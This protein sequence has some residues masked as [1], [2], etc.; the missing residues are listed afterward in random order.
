[1][2]LKVIFDKTVFVNFKIS[3]NFKQKIYETHAK[4]LKTPKKIH[5]TLWILNM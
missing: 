5:P 4:Q 2:L 1:M 3:N